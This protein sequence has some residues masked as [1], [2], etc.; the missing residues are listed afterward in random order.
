MHGLSSPGGSLMSVDRDLSSWVAMPEELFAGG[1]LEEMT[2]SFSA[3]LKNASLLFDR[4]CS[5]RVFDSGS[6]VG[7][8]QGLD[9]FSGQQTH[10]IGPA[11]SDGTPTPTI[12]PQYA[13]SEGMRI[14]IINYASCC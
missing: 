10:A 8:T 12:C 5:P 4:R 11:S 7:V 1:G 2:A 6:L 13:A 9:S 14:K 3:Q